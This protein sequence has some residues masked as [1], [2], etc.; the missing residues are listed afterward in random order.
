[1][2]NKFIFELSN[3]Q[4]HQLVFNSASV[5][6]KVC[7]FQ[8]STKNSF[9]KLSRTRERKTQFYIR[10]KQRILYYFERK[11]NIHLNLKLLFIFFQLLNK[12]KRKLLIF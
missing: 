5:E 6:I 9:N 11:K 4:I 10:F 8:H 7:Q 1:M 3:P 12:N 2:F